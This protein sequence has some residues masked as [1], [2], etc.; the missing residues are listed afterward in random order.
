MNVPSKK[1]IL[2]LLGISLGMVLI[3]AACGVEAGSS[4]PAPNLAINQPTITITVSK[5]TNPSPVPNSSKT[6]AP[7]PTSSPGT[8]TEYS[9]GALWLRL[10]T[11]QDDQVFTTAQIMVDGQA[12]AETVI[13]VNDQIF[14]VG[15][16]QSFSIPVILDEGPNVIEIIASDVYGNEIDLVLTIVYDPQGES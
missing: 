6:P 2:G 12:P 16:D 10:F 15:S 9:S 11:P 8:V 1:L 5:T 7:S 14:I 3:I 13:G 4:Q